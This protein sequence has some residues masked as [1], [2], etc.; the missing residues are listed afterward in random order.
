MTGGLMPVERLQAVRKEIIKKWFL[1]TSD[2]EEEMNTYG[3]EELYE[4]VEL[5]NT[6]NN[7][8]APWR[9]AAARKN[10]EDF[11]GRE[12]KQGDVYYQRQYG[13]A[14]DDTIQL[15]RKSMEDIIFC[16]FSGNV[17]LQSFTKSLK[18]KNIEQ[19]LETINKVN[20]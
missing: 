2:A 17:G 5:L 11:F 6:L 8:Y 16:L 20:F 1:S 3:D 18:E 4:R 13:Q 9:A 19:M 12:I 15:S 14:Y 7:S 10:D